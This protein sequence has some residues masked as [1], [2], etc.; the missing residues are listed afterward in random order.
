[1]Q[2]WQKR[3]VE[4]Q[5]ELAERVERLEAFTKTAQFKGLDR[6]E[7]ELL[8]CQLL[9]MEIYLLTLNNRIAHFIREGKDGE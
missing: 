5:L 7:R 9:H 8:R 2:D 6:Y 4:E 1:M 3:V